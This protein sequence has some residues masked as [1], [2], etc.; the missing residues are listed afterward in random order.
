MLERAA[1]DI[2]AR[3]AVGAPRRVCAS[4]ARSADVRVRI[5]DQLLTEMRTWI[6]PHLLIELDA[7][8]CSRSAAEKPCRAPSRRTRRGRRG[9]NADAVLISISYDHLDLP[10]LRR[11]DRSRLLVVRA[12]HGR[13][14]KAGLPAVVEVEPGERST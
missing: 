4:D 6:G 5:G 14:C 10:S 3:R 13:S 8:G 1:S 9:S 11:L 7:R 12:E 2:A